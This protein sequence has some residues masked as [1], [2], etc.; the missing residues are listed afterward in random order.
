MPG[1]L[2]GCGKEWVF[3]WAPACPSVALSPA[4]SFTHPLCQPRGWAPSA[5]VWQSVCLETSPGSVLSRLRL[6]LG[7]VIVT[8]GLPMQIYRAMSH[9]PE[10]ALW[11]AANPSAV[12]EKRP[13]TQLTFS[14]LGFFWKISFYASLNMHRS[15]KHR[16]PWVHHVLGRYSLEPRHEEGTG[17]SLNVWQCGCYSHISRGRDFIWNIQ[18][19]WND[20]F[21]KHKYILRWI[22]TY[23]VLL[24]FGVYTPPP[25]TADYMSNNLWPQ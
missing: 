19:P 25:T 6:W 5:V 10:H 16:I 3:S 17:F 11:R 9:R 20:V 24:E 4:P 15:T 7:F 12:G 14:G 2:R 13:G 18:V 1:E 21:T 22:W 8:Q 23:L